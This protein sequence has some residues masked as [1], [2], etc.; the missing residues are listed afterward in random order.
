MSSSTYSARILRSVSRHWWGRSLRPVSGER[1]TAV[2]LSPRGRRRRRRRKKRRISWTSVGR[3][4]TERVI[5]QHLASPYDYPTESMCFIGVYEYATMTM[6]VQ[7][8]YFRL[9]MQE[10]SSSDQLSEPM[11]V[12]CLVITRDTVANC[13]LYVHTRDLTVV[14]YMLCILVFRTRN[15]ATNTQQSPTPPRTGNKCMHVTLHHNLTLRTCALC[16]VG[17]TVCSKPGVTN[18]KSYL[19]PKQ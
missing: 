12:T 11:F 4:A 14:T 9:I 16:T 17:C 10:Y 8:V 6:K 18:C 13:L 7:N 15:I 5:P 2:S 1:R 19:S 3:R